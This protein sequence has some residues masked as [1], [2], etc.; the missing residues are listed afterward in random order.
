M[1][2]RYSRRARNSQ[3]IAAIHLALAETTRR[4]VVAF[5]FMPSRRAIA[6]ANHLPH[7]RHLHFANAS[8]IGRRRRP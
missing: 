7:A 8:A 2:A 3:R 6:S 1:G 4:G 5:S